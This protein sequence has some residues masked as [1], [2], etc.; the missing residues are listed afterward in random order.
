MMQVINTSFSQGQLPQINAI[1]FYFFVISKDEPCTLH[2]LVVMLALSQAMSALAPPTLTAPT[3]LRFTATHNE[4]PQEG[5]NPP[6]RDTATG[7]TEGTDG[8]TDRWTP[9]HCIDP[10]AYYAS[11]VNN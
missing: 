5:V 3:A 9:Y 4:T 2:S 6:Y 8:Q 11:S 1:C 7:Q 10:A